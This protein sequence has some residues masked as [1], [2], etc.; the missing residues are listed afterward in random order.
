METLVKSVCLYAQ[1]KEVK[2]KVTGNL[3]SYLEILI[4]NGE[5]RLREMEK[6]SSMKEK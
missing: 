1:V 3:F 6:A 5:N 4:H 2:L